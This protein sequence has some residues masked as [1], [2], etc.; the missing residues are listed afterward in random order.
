MYGKV[1]D[2]QNTNEVPSRDDLHQELSAIHVNIP[3]QVVSSSRITI[4][5]LEGS[6]TRIRIP[7]REL[8]TTRITI[9]NGTQQR[10]GSSANLGINA[11]RSG[12]SSVLF[13]GDDGA[14]KVERK[15]T[16]SEILVAATKRMSQSSLP[17]IFPES[18]GPPVSPVLNAEDALE[19]TGGKGAAGAFCEHMYPL[20]TLSEHFQTHIDF[21]APQNSRGLTQNQAADIMKEFGLN[22]LTP[23][24]KVPLWLLFLL[25]FTNIL[26]MMLMMV[27]AIC[28]ALFISDT[29]NYDN[30]YIGVLLFAAVFITCYETFSQEAKSD[31]LME[32]FRAMVPAQA[33]VIRDGVMKPTD[34]AQIVIGDLIRLKSGDKV[35]ADCRIIYNMSMKVRSDFIVLLYAIK[36]N[37]IYFVSIIFILFKYIL[38]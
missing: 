5:Q 30:L 12:S 13:R 26:I 7:A 28:I 10:Q 36:Y 15:T 31:S 37:N 24:P 9:G 1:P 35:P 14:V 34:A 29:S 19:R 6:T 3:P 2:E 18:A 27:A 20:E 8:S 32:K 16:S 38:Y 11:R 21:H 25:Q 22:V 4:P 17:S 33:S 23:P